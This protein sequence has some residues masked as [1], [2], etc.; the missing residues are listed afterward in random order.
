[1][2]TDNYKSLL[3]ET[4]EDLN[5]WKGIPCS[6]SGRLNTVTV[7]ILSKAIYSSIDLYQNPNGLFFKSKK[8][9]TLK[10]IW[11]CKGLQIAQKILKKKNKVGGLILPSF[12]TH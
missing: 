12:K 11:N 6:S 3:K 9:Q 8:K 4:K 7:A 10:L 2:Y 5:K 1:M